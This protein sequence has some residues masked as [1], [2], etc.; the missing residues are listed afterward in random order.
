MHDLIDHGIALPKGD[1]AIVL[2]ARHTRGFETSFSESLDKA[3]EAIDRQ[4]LSEL[5]AV[6]LR[7]AIEGFSRWWVKLTMRLCS[8]NYF[9]NFVSEK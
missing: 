7:S 3:L 1:D 6:D 5:V 8:I 2:N 9:K 4:E